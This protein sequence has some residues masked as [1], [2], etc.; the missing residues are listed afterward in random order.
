M[1]N[2]VSPEAEQ[3][4]V[5][6]GELGA[7]VPSS[8][9]ESLEVVGIGEL[10]APIRGKIILACVLQA[11]SSVIGLIPLIAVAELARV[12]FGDDE[13]EDGDLWTIAIVAAVA[14]VA[15]L[16]FLFAGSAV[17]HFADN[18]L[19]LDLRRRL[20][21]HMGRVPLG[22]F[23]AHDGGDI[24]KVVVDDVG[25]MHHL[26]GHTFTDITAAIVT[27]IVAMG[28]LF[29]VDWPLSLIVLV[30]F[31]LGA[32]LYSRQMQGYTEKMADYNQALEEIN[33]G[34]VEFVQG[35]SVI[36]TFGQSGRSHGRFISA[37]NRFVDYF[38]TWVSGLLRVSSLAEVA[39][40]P[41]M[42]LTVIATAGTWFV[43]R[44]WIAPVDLVI[45]FLIGLALTAPI[46][47]LGYAMNDIQ[48][49]SDA[50]ARVGRLLAVPPLAEAEQPQIPADDT[51][52]FDGV[53]FSYDGDRSVL[54]DIDLRLEPGKVTALVG[55][56]GS[57]KSTLAKLLCRFWDPTE[58]SIRLGGVA[59]EDI[60]RDELY[61]R[62][63]FVFQDV[64]LLRASVA[65]NIA[66]AEPSAS[67][68]EIEVAARAANIHDRIAALPDGY[69]SIVGET[70]L[71]S[72]GEAQR[73]SIARALLADAPIL[74]LDEATSFADPESEAVVQ[75]ALSTL[76]AGRTMVVIAHRLSTIVGADEIVVLR[77]GE[78]V[79]RGRHG[80]LVAAGGEY[81]RQ[82]LADQRVAQPVALDPGDI[83]GGQ[84]TDGAIERRTT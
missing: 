33:V 42:T 64:Q 21:D 54:R 84:N 5:V 27:S 55:P 79:E 81:E 53:G 39:L 48:L 49:A 14:M 71:L 62:V 28:Y 61:G 6:D 45:F 46:L 65:D 16:V 34:A 40:S 74:V 44:D 66:L 13:P 22:W 77:D 52:V 36:K 35:I 30:P 18:D 23:D 43:S 7:G 72:G 60:A 15:R 26:V 63:G 68:N 57:G 76:A 12:L 37:A 80:D 10:L 3:V 73:V 20:A 1:A 11:I 51:V 31:L 78:I 32:F 38:W 41:L 82:W 83:A 17:T 56:S 29:L 58:G 24:K 50:A 19:Q 59:L 9:V 47:T 8:A 75:D 2:T 67:R 4:D 69:D 25:S 70:A